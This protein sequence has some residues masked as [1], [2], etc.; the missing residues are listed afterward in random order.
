MKESLPRNPSEAFASESDAY[1]TSRGKTPGERESERESVLEG[2]NREAAAYA[3]KPWMDVAV[4]LHDAKNNAASKLE[5]LDEG[6][7]VYDIDGQ[8]SLDDLVRYGERRAHAAAEGK[9]GDEVSPDEAAMLDAYKAEAQMEQAKAECNVDTLT[10]DQMRQAWQKATDHLKAARESGD[11]EEEKR[12]REVARLVSDYE[13]FHTGEV[14]EDDAPAMKKKLYPDANNAGFVLGMLDEN[15]NTRDDGF[16][17][18]DKFSKQAQ[19]DTRNMQG[20]TDVYKLF[21]EMQSQSAEP[22]RASETVV[23][24]PQAAAAEAQARKE[25]ILAKHLEYKEAFDKA[26]ATLDYDAMLGDG[27]DGFA[28][29]RQKIENQLQRYRG[30]GAAAAGNVKRLERLQQSLSSYIEDTKKD[31]YEFPEASS[32]WKS[33]RDR[34]EVMKFLAQQYAKQET[35]V[36]SKNETRDAY[37]PDDTII[38]TEEKGRTVRRLNVAN[39]YFFES[40]HQQLT[41]ENIKVLKDYMVQELRGEI[42]YAKRQNSRVP[43]SQETMFQ[44]IFT[45]D[46][47]EDASRATT[48][49]AYELVKQNTNPDLM[50]AQFEQM[51]IKDIAQAVGFDI[52]EY[53]EDYDTRVLPHVAKQV[54]KEKPYTTPPMA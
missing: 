30:E 13:E 51:S 18:V 28:S 50:Y 7:T 6:E 1:D 43:G 21:G 24:A 25:Q 40:Q 33:A 53:V 27:D 3:A 17:T 45:L 38:P 44:P 54:D 12:W 37:N 34:S 42:D 19:R 5:L 11:K 49:F 39:K 2:A 41:P 14:S 31:R 4:D 9:R 26:E 52:T 8:G 46:Q 10:E 23:D 20:M 22:V 47:L 29:A 32:D 15:G 16:G 36:D 35:P 48:K